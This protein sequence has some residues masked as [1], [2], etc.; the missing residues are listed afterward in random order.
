VPAFLP[1]PVILNRL[2]AEYACRSKQPILTTILWDSE[3]CARFLAIHFR[4]EC[5]GARIVPGSDCPPQVHPLSGV[6]GRVPEAASV[7]LVTLLLQHSRLEENRETSWDRQG[8]TRVLAAPMSA[9]RMVAAAI[10]ISVA[11]ATAIYG[12][13]L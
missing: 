2:Q 4:E 11:L 13:A 9:M 1:S 7:S 6:A 3:P 5:A 8:G 10:A 12:N